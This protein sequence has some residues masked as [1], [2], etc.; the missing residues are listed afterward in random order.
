MSEGE[1]FAGIMGL[2]GLLFFVIFIAIFVFYMLSLSKALRLAGEENRQMEPGLVWL[3]L[4]PVFNLGWII[5]TVLKVSEAITN[6]HAANGTPDPSQG[7]KTIGLLY[8][9]FVIVSIIPFIGVLFGLASLVL[10]II[11][12]VKISGYNK[13]MEQMSTVAP[14]PIVE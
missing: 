3:N 7:A 14:Q 5:Y 8:T 2:F 6:K 13:A 1:M 9:I 11:Y 10:W 4:I 12:W